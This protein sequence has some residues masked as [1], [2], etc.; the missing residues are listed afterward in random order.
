MGTA[1]AIR[2]RVP[3][4][5]ASS[6]LSSSSSLD[7]RNKIGAPKDMEW[8]MIEH[9]DSSVSPAGSTDVTMATSAAPGIKL[10]IKEMIASGSKQNSSNKG[11]EDTSG[12]SDQPTPPKMITLSALNDRANDTMGKRIRSLGSV[13]ANEPAQKKP[14]QNNLAFDRN[15][16]H[17]RNQ[18]KEKEIEDEVKRSSQ[19]IQ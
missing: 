10:S 8:N 5:G 19:D 12:K 16:E 7:D 13:V 3:A 18:D 2:Q 15:P 6:E 4:I 11:I 14:P 1:E 9:M 17:G